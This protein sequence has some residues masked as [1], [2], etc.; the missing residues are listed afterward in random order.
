VVIPEAKEFGVLDKP[1][2]SDP[3]CL[4]EDRAIKISS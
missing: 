3:I 1:K 4:Q 2:I